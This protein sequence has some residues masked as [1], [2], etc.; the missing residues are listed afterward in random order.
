ME[1]LR[2]VER[3]LWTLGCVFLAIPSI[4]WLESKAYQYYFDRAFESQIAT[5]SASLETPLSEN[6]TAGAARRTALPQGLIGKIEI[7]DLDLSAMVQSGVDEV[8][9]RRGVGHLPSSPFPGEP[10]NVVL[11]GHRDTFF[12][13]LEWVE[14]GDLISLETLDGRF[15][16]RVQWTAVVSPDAISVLDPTSEKSL[17]LV[18]CYPFTYIGAAP[19]RFIVRA[20]EISQEQHH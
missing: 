4:M 16:Y 3:L 20:R 14:E 11:A 17:T 15:L 6:T 19:E 5:I 18:T 8:S 9:L 12:R 7:E 13:P 10:G 2:W 1:S